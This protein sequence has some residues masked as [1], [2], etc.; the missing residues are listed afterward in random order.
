MPRESS[1]GL[2][3]SLKAN[4]SVFSQSMEML[5]RYWSAS[6]S[7]TCAETRVFIFNLTGS[8]CFR[9]PEEELMAPNG[10]LFSCSV[11][12]RENSVMPGKWTRVP[13]QLY[14]SLKS[15]FTERQTEFSFWKQR[16]VISPSRW[17]TLS[18]VNMSRKSL[19]MSSS[20]GKTWQSPPADWLQ[21][22]S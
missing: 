11:P 13:L 2:L 6:V 3:R 22:S 12:S 7:H 16:R 15:V 14:N 19:Y 10:F 8:I 9:R 4:R 21:Y 18:S 17:D 20:K 5:W 1:S